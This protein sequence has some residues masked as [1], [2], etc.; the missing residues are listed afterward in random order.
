MS[1]SSFQSAGLNLTT[2]LSAASL[3]AFQSP[4]VRSWLRAMACTLGLIGLAAL[5]WGV[6]KYGPGVFA[7]DFSNIRH[8]DYRMFKNPTTTP[9][10]IFGIPH[11][12]IGFAFLLSSRRMREPKNKVQ[13]AVL[14][15]IGIGFCLLFRKVGANLNIFAVFIFY[16]YFLIHG[17]RDDAHFYKTF[18]DMPREAAATHDRIL[19]VLQALQ[20]GLLFSLFWPTYAHVASTDIRRADPILSNFFPASWP[21]ILKLGSMFI[22]MV[23]I[24]LIA[25]HRVARNV[26]G[27]LAGLWRLHRPLFMVF[28]LS[29]GVLGLAMFGGPGAFD[30][31][32]LMHFVAWYF[33]ALFMLDRHP[34]KEPPKS[35][36]AWMRTT[37]TGFVTL[38]TGLVILTALILCVSVYVFGQKAG[39]LDVIV[40]KEA[41][42]YWTIM[43][44]TWSWV[45]R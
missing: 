8:S 34:P 33:F 32:V 42:Y 29:L 15:V 43:H 2:P 40:G 38:H 24:T 41:F 19:I 14:T 4:T 3:G 9:M 6:D 10:R 1:A 17:F 37:R 30:I 44:V 12:F 13:L 28:V 18:G 25:L 5:F 20:I 36:W 11:F 23:I 39:A 26:D 7:L 22:P 35:T 21:F 16:F 31:W 27:G 45:P